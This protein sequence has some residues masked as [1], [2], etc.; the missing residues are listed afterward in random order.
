MVRVVA[1]RSGPYRAGRGVG[2]RHLEVKVNR[3][4]LANSSMKDSCVE[5]GDCSDERNSV[6]IATR[7]E[8]LDVAADQSDDVDPTIP[9]YVAVS[10]SR[11]MSRSCRTDWGG[12]RPNPH[13]IAAPNPV[14]DRVDAMRRLAPGTHQ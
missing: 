6:R 7:G 3:H 4:G 11:C 2:G 13:S 10:R 14:T 1:S 5:S 8:L 12:R 9:S